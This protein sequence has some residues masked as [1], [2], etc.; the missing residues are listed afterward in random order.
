LR[1]RLHII[2]LLCFIGCVNQTFAQFN[3]T[4]TVYDSTK[5]NYVEGVR[6]ETNTGKFTYT[7]S[8]GKYGL[9]V[10]ETD[11]VVFTF[12]NKPTQKF[13]V[14]TIP[15]PNV[16]D[17]W[18]HVKVKGKYTTLKEVIVRANSYRQDSIENRRQYD[19]VFNHRNGKVGTSIVP[20]GGVG[21][22]IN[23]LINLFRFRR[24]KQLKAFRNRL[25]LEEKER[26]IN[27]RFNKTLVTRIT[28]LKNAELDTFMVKYRPDYEFVQ[29]SDE[30]SF[31]EYII[32]AWYHYKMEMLKPTPSS[33]K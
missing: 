20:G 25:E 1:V 26:Y 33:S 17:I 11:S 10:N 12:R 22:D 30:L 19:D 9:R 24:N 7:D 3:L 2:I 29:L 23:D 21:I 16:F 32:N 31:N 14:K 6:V 5:I 15:N 13:A 27:Y 28:G 18:I 8:V 4:G